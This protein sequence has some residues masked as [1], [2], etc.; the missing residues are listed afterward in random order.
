MF[1]SQGHKMK[2]P[3]VSLTSIVS[4]AFVGCTQLS[5]VAGGGSTPVTLQVNFKDG[6]ARNFHSK[7][8]MEVKM[9]QSPASSG[10]SSSPQQKVKWSMD[11]DMS[12]SFS[13][14]KVGTAT[15]TTKVSNMKMSSD[16]PLPNMPELPKEREMSATM[17][18]Q[19]KISNLNIGV[20]WDPL[21]ILMPG[22]SGGSLGSSSFSPV[23]PNHPVKP[24]NTWELP[25]PELPGLKITGPTKMT[26]LGEKAIDGHA[27]YEMTSTGDLNLEMDVSKFFAGNFGIAQTKFTGQLSMKM[28]YDVEKDT[29]IMFKMV[30]TSNTSMD[31]GFM[32]MKMVMDMDISPKQ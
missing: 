2:L 20:S 17:D 5:R 21:M 13:N 24:G 1:V 32:K 10:T 15:Y 6:L 28:T 11:S 22:M 12:V 19:G 27:V 25:N 4:I 30:G 31:M 29:G 16:T 3:I 8:T 9:D 14:V 26:F 23:F 7:I 18:K